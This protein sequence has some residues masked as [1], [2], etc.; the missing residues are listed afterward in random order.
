MVVVLVLACAASRALASPLQPDDTRPTF[1]G[2][3]ASRIALPRVEDPDA[4]GVVIDGNLDEPAWSRAARLTGFSQYQPIDG[5]PAREHTEV[6]VWYSP[7]SLYFAIV[8]ED[9]EPLSI[10][11]TSAD[12]DRLDQEDTVTV[13]LDTF[14]DRRRAF[15]FGVNPFGIQEDGVQTEGASGT[16]ANRNDGSR[17]FGTT[18]DKS[19]DYRFESKGHMTPTGYL[20]ELR[21]PFKSLRFPNGTRQ[22]W[23]LNVLR[24]VQRTGY[25]DTWTEVRRSNPSFLAQAASI[26]L[27]DLKRGVVAEVQ[28]FVTAALAG[29]RSIDRARF[30]RGTPNPDVGFNARLGVSGLSLDATVNPDFSQVESDAGLVTVN[31]RF[32]LFYNEKRPFFLEGIELFATPNQLVYTRRIVDPL[33]GAKLTGKL[34]PFGV[35]Y[36]TALDERQGRRHLVTAARLRTDLGA[37]SSAGITVTDRESSLDANR[38]LAAD[39]RIVFARLY[40]VQGQ[41]GQSWSTA[42]GTGR[43]APL[44]LGEFDRTGRNFGFNYKVNAV[45][46][47]F[48]ASTGYVPR[49]DAVE[50]HAFN[51]L[52]FFGPPGNLVES[53]R[54]QLNLTRFWQYGGFLQAPPI[55]GDDNPNVTLLLR[56][57]WNVNTAIRR[58]FF[59]FDPLNY[60]GYE[61][62][63]AD[64]TDAFRPPPGVSG[65]YSADVTV[66]TPVYREFN[67]SFEMRRGGAALF[68]EA[69]RGRERRYIATANVRP[70]QSIRLA[71]TMTLVRLLREADGSEFARTAIPRLVMEYQA[72]RTIFVR[73]V[74]EF[75]SER[76][77][78]FRDLQLRPLLAGGRP[79]E[80]DDHR[81]LRVDALFSYQPTPGTVAFFGYGSTLEPDPARLAGRLSRS[82]DGFFVKLSYLFRQ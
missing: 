56:G 67:G 33:A 77:A 55:E 15:F 66:T 10:R 46:K 60:A 65:L 43:T 37:A 81:G 39:A 44:W 22:S 26:E 23:R 64:A 69:A 40:Y 74:G 5:R 17:R 78:P 24:K 18:I 52:S 51:R 11:A 3:G 25:Q 57:G 20:V 19:P 50:A 68:G 31:E 16:G 79:I 76:Y 63:T 2:R 32:A 49:Q 71:A 9:R 13:F 53:V 59:R 34:G 14:A 47:D 45:G 27:H 41:I 4:E 29:E 61:V 75:R 36:L 38:V 30:V 8:A 62:A 48:E 70:A 35:A 73:L 72:T 82:S 7:S 28:P 6:L 42:G 80:P 54:L 12:R 1:D 21:I 58:D